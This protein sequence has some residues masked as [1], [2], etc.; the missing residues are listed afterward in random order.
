MNRHSYSIACCLAAA[1]CLLQATTCAAF[2][3]GQQE[4]AP[5][6]IIGDKAAPAVASVGARHLSQVQL[7]EP[8]PGMIVGEKEQAR[9]RIIEEQAPGRIIEEQAPGR[10]IFGNRKLRQVQLEER[11]GC[12]KFLIMPCPGV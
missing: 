5:G 2:L 4:Q 11:V 7:A 9:G 6:R 12:S 8:A 1:L 10:I 3:V